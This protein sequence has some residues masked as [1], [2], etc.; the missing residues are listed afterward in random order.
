MRLSFLVVDND[1]RVV[2]RSTARVWL[3]RALDEKPFAETTAH[4]ERIGVEGSEEGDAEE[5]FVTHL[6]LDTPGKYWVLA[7]LVGGRKIQA[8]GNVVVAKDTAAPS[9]GDPAVASKTPTIES[10]GGDLEALTTQTPPDREMLRHSVADSIEAEV[11]F[12][13]TFA[14]P[15]YCTTRTCGPVVDVVDAVRKQ[16]EPD[17]VRF[18]HVEIYAENDPAKG[19]N[20]WVQEW[21]LPSEPFTFLVGADGL[22]K[23][24]FEGTFSVRELGEAVEQ[25]LIPG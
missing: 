18:I 7:E 23:E 14:T 25:H 21:N 22:V 8:I 11:P 20:A 19:T 3:S 1:G 24:R 5:I 10:T 6:E 9:V 17:G 2:T 4:A 16:H 12:V 15:R 13:V